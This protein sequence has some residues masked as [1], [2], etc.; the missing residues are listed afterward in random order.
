MHGRALLILRICLASGLIGGAWASPLLRVA[1][2]ETATYP[3]LLIDATGHASGGVLKELGDKL[4]ERLG[5][6]AQHLI[7]SRRRLEDSVELGAA[8]ISCYLSPSWSDHYAKTGLWSIATLPQIERLVVPAS[9]AIPRIIPEDFVGKRVAVIFGYHYPRIQPLF[10]EGKAE[11]V[12]VNRVGQLFRL[13]EQGSADVLIS[14][15]AEIS[16]YLNANPVDKARFTVGSTAF[17]TV[18]TQCLVSPRSPWSLGRINAVLEGMNADG[19][20]RRLTERYGMS[21]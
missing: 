20:L 15:E 9:K 19:T 21:M 18:E 17:T 14:S 8:D 16:S 5:T 7:F 12:D 11:R 4:A 6:S 1:Q 3:L 10:D 2:P 13:L